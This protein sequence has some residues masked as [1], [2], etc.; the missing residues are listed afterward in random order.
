MIALIQRCTS[1]IGWCD[2]LSRIFQSATNS[3]LCDE[4]ISWLC[5]RKNLPL[6]EVL[7]AHFRIWNDMIVRCWLHLSWVLDKVLVLQAYVVAVVSVLMSCGLIG[8]IMAIFAFG[9]E[10]DS[11][12]IMSVANKPF[13]GVS[14]VVACRYICRIN[15]AAS[16]AIL[17]HIASLKIVWNT[18]VKL[19]ATCRLHFA[20]SESHFLSHADCLCACNGSAWLLVWCAAIVHGMVSKACIGWVASYVVLH[21]CRVVCSALVCACHTL[22]E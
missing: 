13:L 10:S 14:R 3:C 18:N 2:D 15:I 12:A 11:D 17:E 7:L 8:R 22:W 21:D 1:I 4:M 9:Q 19:T 16:V 6:L 20:L 5:R